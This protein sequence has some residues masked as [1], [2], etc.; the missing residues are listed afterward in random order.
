MKRPQNEPQRHRGHRGKKHREKTKIERKRG[1][2][3][4]CLDSTCLFS[5]VLLS[6]SSVPLWFVLFLEPQFL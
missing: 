1:D 2:P 4:F 5:V 3:A 6:F